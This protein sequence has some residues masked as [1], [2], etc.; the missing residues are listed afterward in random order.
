MES[1][2]AARL[3]KEIPSERAVATIVPREEITAV[4]QDLG[5]EPELYLR[6]TG[7]GLEDDDRNMIGMTWSR[8]DLEQL[9]ER[10]TG[11]EVV[12]TFDRDELSE[13]LL[14]DVEGHGL[15]ERAVVF[16]VV[17]AGALGTG[18]GIANAMPTGDG[19]GAVVTQ[20]APAAPA[21]MVTDASSGAG[22][23][24]AQGQADNLVSDA[25]SG[26]GYVA[27]GSG[28]AADSMVT[29]ASSAA[30]YTAPAATASAS[31]SMVSDAASGSGYTAPAAAPAS[32]AGSLRTD[33]SSTGGYGP[34]VS[35]DSSG[36]GMLSINA[37]STT[38]GLVAG[39]I[40]LAIAG[41]TF[42]SRRH[43]G[44]SRPA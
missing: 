33:A 37:P 22:Y 26:A 44:T 4:L 12:F 25:A 2:G 28:T 29:D 15:R 43:T 5:S 16:A 23:L 35:T 39:G 34:A 8:D 41:A 27:T 42:A 38:D 20:V 18:A 7:D 10:A 9:L 32:P 17:A 31:D 11:D 24:T 13:A 1:L 36:G 14:A 21:G 40:L 19:G 30:G 6:M 3:A